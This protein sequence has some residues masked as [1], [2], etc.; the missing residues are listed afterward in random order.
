M[1][2][3]FTASSLETAIKNHVADQGSDFDDNVNTLIKLAED[4]ILKDLP[5]AIFDARGDVSITAGTQTATKPS[6]T[7]TMRELYYTSSSVRYI[8]LPRTYSFCL[9]YSTNTT[10]ATPKYFAEDY[11]STQIY[12]S[13][14]PNV[15]VTAEALITKRP[16]SI[17]D[18]STFIGTNLGD[19]LFNACLITANRFGLA[20]PEKQDAQADYDRALAS[21]QIT[22]RHLLPRDYTPLAPQ[23]SAAGKQER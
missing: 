18:G 10:Q 20:T 5:L 16:D 17:V 12:I 9:D 7:I 19:L 23:P 4:M 15:T 22:L 1:S 8:L 14:S 6:G 2:T 21:A 13:P 3:S 11:S